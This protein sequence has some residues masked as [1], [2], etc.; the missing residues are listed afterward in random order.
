MKNSCH[1]CDFIAI[2][3]GSY[4]MFVL[5]SDRRTW[6]LFSCCFLLATHWSCQM[7]LTQIE[8]V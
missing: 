4:C 5:A 3:F 1:C 2:N 8:N 7:L 6:R